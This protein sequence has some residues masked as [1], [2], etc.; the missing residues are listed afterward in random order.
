MS[1]RA[2]GLALA[3]LG[4]AALA[5]CA[6]APPQPD[7]VQLK[8][9]DLDAR[10]TRIERVVQNRSLLQIANQ[11]EA[12]RADLRSVHDSVDQMRHEIDQNQRRDHDLYADLDAR[13]TKLENRAAAGGAAPAAGT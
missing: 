12:A 3:A 13:L 2:A 10:L 6:T 5:G 9:N 1:A 4:V 11:I 8:L 7:P